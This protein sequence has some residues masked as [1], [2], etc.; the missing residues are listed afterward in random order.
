MPRLVYNQ[1]HGRNRSHHAALIHL[2]PK[3]ETAPHTHDFTEIFLVT[4]GR[5]IERRKTGDIT[6][7]RG[8]LGFVRPSDRH[9]FINGPRESIQF[10]NLAF[11]PRWWTR[12]IATPGVSLPAAAGRNL[13]EEGTSRL[14]RLLHELLTNPEAPGLLL[15]IAA[16]S[17]RRLRPGLSAPAATG[18]KGIPEWLA[19]WSDR[20]SE[21]TVSARPLADLQQAS[22]RSAEHLARS[23]RRYYGVPPTE[24]ITRARIAAVQANL[25][26]GNQKIAAAVFEAGFQNLGYFYRSF[27][28]LVGTTPRAW[29]AKQA[30]VATVPR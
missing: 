1:L 19:A 28:R 10:I 12:F 25:R 3:P 29:L 8:W 16:V 20:L 14:E 2:S 26:G 30:V 6:L 27:R 13:D 18:T 4:K 17:L 23:C 15:E 9:S 11:A 24:L 22:G 7:T 5:G 21:P